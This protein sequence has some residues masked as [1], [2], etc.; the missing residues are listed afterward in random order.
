MHE[1]WLKTNRRILLLGMILPAV[2]LVIGLIVLMTEP[3]SGAVWLRILSWILLGC[4]LFLLA[5]LSLQ[6][7]LPRLAYV[8][9][10]LLV[11]L[12]MGPPF[13]VPTEVVECFFLGTG[14]GQIPGKSGEEVPVR[15]VVIRVAEKAVE[16]HQR[17]VK[18]A[19]GRWE[20][21]YI[22][23]YGAW[24]EPLDVELAKRLNARLA[25]VKLTEKHG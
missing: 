6:F 25:E 15:N 10:N 8:D 18:P 17:E 11:Y 2:L 9:G 1:T 20:E 23:I 21:G 5:I 4:G 14:A 24:C 7:R 12:R 19:L 13:H 3:L 22:T 16:Y